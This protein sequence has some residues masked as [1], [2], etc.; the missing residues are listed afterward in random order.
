VLTIFII[1]RHPDVQVIGTSPM[2]F[3]E[4]ATGLLTCCWKRACPLDWPRGIWDS[5]I[6]YLA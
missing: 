2:V 1:Y 4:A 5:E 6:M 3:K